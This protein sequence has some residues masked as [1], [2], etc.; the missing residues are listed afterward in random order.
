MPQKRTESDRRLRQAGRLA[1]IF[2]IL[3]RIQ[4]RGRWNAKALAEELECTERTVYRYLKV[5][6]FAGVPYYVDP[7]T[8]SYK[9]RSDFR[10]PVV[11]LT[12]D[13]LLGQALASS[14]TVVVGLDVNDGA[15]PATKKLAATASEETQQMLEAV[16]RIVT[17]LDLQL[18]DHS[19]HHE[20][21]RTV[22]WALLDQKQI[23]GHYESPYEDGPINLRLHPYRLALI[24]KAWYIIG[25]LVNEEKPRTYR[26]ARFQTLRRLSS[27]AEVP[28]DFDIRD[29]LGNAWAVYRGAESFE[30]EIMFVGESARVVT[31]TVWHH[32]Q[33]VKQHKDGS[34]TLTFTVDG[35]DEITNWLLRW[36]GSFIVVTPDALRE[37]VAERLK[38]ALRMNTSEK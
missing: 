38:S 37:R 2:R 12:S 29:Y 7:R 1:D 24:K 16:S 8:K 9:V 26:V 11:N 27:N 17:A 15:E 32:T 33:K 28:V 34:A 3:E 19:R 4:S 25:R 23:S 18:V 36:A 13:E 10:F 5:L 21:I 35:L 22:Q 6:E 14:L 20:V 30:I 31:E